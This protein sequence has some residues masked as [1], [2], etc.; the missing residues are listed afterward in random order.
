VRITALEVVEKPAGLP[1]R[2]VIPPGNADVREDDPNVDTGADITADG[3]VIHVAIPRS[4]RHYIA[5]I[6]MGATPIFKEVDWAQ[7]RHRWTLAR[8]V[9]QPWRSSAM[10]ALPPS[11]NPCITGLS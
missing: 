10:A 7:A 9:N 5:G 2:S 3:L 4:R 6:G 11:R 1:T 8:P